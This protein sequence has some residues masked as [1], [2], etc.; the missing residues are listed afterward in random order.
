MRVITYS[1]VP[2][3]FGIKYGSLTIALINVAN[4]AAKVTGYLIKHGVYKNQSESFI[5]N[6]EMITALVAAVIAFFINYYI[7]DVLD[8]LTIYKFRKD[9][10]IFADFN[11]EM[12][13]NVTQ[14]VFIDLVGNM[15]CVD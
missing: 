6:A 8:V 15:S 9:L 4:F 13:P 5:N 14:S 11:I 3:V 12:D 10:I 2:K 7:S 1:I